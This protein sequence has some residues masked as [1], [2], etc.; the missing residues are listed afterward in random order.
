VADLYSLRSTR[1]RVATRKLQA[2]LASALLLS[3]AEPA[4]AQTTPTRTDIT[5]AMAKDPM[6]FYLA[7]GEPDACGPGC[8][9]WIAAEGHI[10]MGAPQRL[11]IQLANLGKRK[12]PIFFHSPGGL[13]GHATEIGRLLRKREMTA[14]VSRTRPAGC[15]T[16]SE[17]SCRSLKRSGQPLVSELSNMAVCNSACVLALIGGKIR[18][19]PPGARVGVHSAK[20]VQL[21]SNGVVKAVPSGRVSADSAAQMRRYHQEM[22]IAAELFDL[23][24][25][26]PHEQIHYLSRDEIAKFGID[27]RE[28]LETRWM[29]WQQAGQRSWAIKLIV[30]ASGTGRKQF[31]LGMIKLACGDLRRAWIAYVRGLGPDEVAAPRSIKLTLGEGDLAFPPKGTALKIESLETGS[32]FET[33]YVHVPLDLLEAVAARESVDI[34]ETDQSDSSTGPRITTL[35]T[36]G[37]AKAL[38]PLQ[39]ECGTQRDKFFDAPAI[40]FLDMSRTSGKQ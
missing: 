25:K 6:L 20:P 18:Q 4:A 12:L 19:V 23:G 38:E 15:A 22:Q 24:A 31:R 36:I 28:F 35:S 29:P 13:G 37:L 1:K 21:H 34:V 39:K 40:R 7:K 32:S 30:E 16:A 8:S 11:R 14:G 10:D 33:R 27:K 9:E 2:L 3:L 17:E 5:T 26:V